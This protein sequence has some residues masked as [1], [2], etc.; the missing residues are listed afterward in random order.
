MKKS[1]QEPSVI[2][3]QLMPGITILNDP[4]PINY[5]GDIPSGVGG[6]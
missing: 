1:Y 4:S 6:D 3:T 2:T 5:G